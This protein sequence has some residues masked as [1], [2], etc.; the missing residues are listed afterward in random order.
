VRT[1][2][3]KEKKDILDSSD[4]LSDQVL[5]LDIVEEGRDLRGS[6][7]EISYIDP[8]EENLGGDPLGTLYVDPAEEI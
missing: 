3:L 4:A 5:G 6:L 2:L 1:P 8:A 7:L